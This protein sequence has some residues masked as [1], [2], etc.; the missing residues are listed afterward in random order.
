MRLKLWRSALLAAACCLVG[1]AGALASDCS[2]LKAANGDSDDRL[3]LAEV[4]KAASEAWRRVHN[5][6]AGTT[7]LTE[8]EERLGSKEL[9][10]GTGGGGVTEK[11]YVEIA[12]SLFKASDPDHEDALDCSELA[13]DPGQAL[14]KLLK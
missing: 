9:A 12:A 13:S 10:A 8:M 5:G 3:E 14:L 6:G 4:K 7:F 1:G 11:E 2:A